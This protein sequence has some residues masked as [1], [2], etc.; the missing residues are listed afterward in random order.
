MY[1]SENWKCCDDFDGKTAEILTEKGIHYAKLVCAHCKHFIK[2]LPNPKN[3]IE[4]EE[5]NKK[6][7]NLIKI[8]ST[9]G[10]KH[11]LFLNNIKQS[12]FLTPRQ[13][14]Y[15]NNILSKYTPKD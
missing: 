11:L 15:F 1:T 3:T 4:H 2:W 9:I 12:R 10:D 5:R 6:I 8:S 7:E 14:E 13:F